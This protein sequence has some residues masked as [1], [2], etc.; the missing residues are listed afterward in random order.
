MPKIFFL[1]LH[2]YSTIVYK[3]AL[4]VL[5]ITINMVK[6]K[7]AV[8]LILHCGNV[9]VTLELTELKETEL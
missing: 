7:F 6:V 1:N 2:R 8:N 3:S 9:R 5:Y 4:A